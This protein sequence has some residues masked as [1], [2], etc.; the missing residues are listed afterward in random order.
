[1]FHNTSINLVDFGFATRYIDEHTGKHLEPQHV[2][3]FRGNMIFSSFN[4]LNFQRTCRR[5]DL[6]SLCY[7]LLFL[8]NDF[9]LP[10]IEFKKTAEDATRNYRIA[11]NA[12]IHTSLSEHI[13]DQSSGI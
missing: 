5:D 11:K 8:L 1:M 7:Y 3:V 12:K 2:D 9:K 13:S 6:I 10:N 4:Q